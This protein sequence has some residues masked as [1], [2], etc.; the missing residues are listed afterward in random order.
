[1][2]D[3]GTTPEAVEVHA[4]VPG[5]DPESMEIS[6]EKGLLTIAGERISDL[7]AVDEKAHVFKRERYAGAFRRVISLSEDV[8]PEQVQAVC[9][10]GILRITAA[11]RATAR[12]RKIDVK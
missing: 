3:I 4:F 2:I 10:N 9:R 11:K 6:V 5:V 8:N 1:M 12:S 7:P